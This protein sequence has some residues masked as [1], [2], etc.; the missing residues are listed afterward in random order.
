MPSISR[1]FLGQR[2]GMSRTMGGRERRGGARC[3]LL[4]LFKLF[5]LFKSTSFLMR[6]GE[7]KGGEFKRMGG[8]GR[9]GGVKER[10]ALKLPL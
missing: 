6:G 10:G 7:G 2:I 4:C 5:K 1:L 8:R 9:R 3:C